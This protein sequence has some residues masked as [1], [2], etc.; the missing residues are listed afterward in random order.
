MGVRRTAGRCLADST[1]CRTG[2][3]YHRVPTAR[4]ARRRPAQGRAR[5]AAQWAACEARGISLVRGSRWARTRSVPTGGVRPGRTHLAV[6]LLVPTQASRATATVAELTLL[7]CLGPLGC[8]GSQGLMGCPAGPG[9]ARVTQDRVLQARAI[10][11]RVPSVPVTQARVLRVRVTRGRVPRVRVTRGR[12][13]LVR[14]TRGQV[15]P[16]RV[17]RVRVTRGRVLRVRVQWVRVT[18]GRVPR[19]RVSRVP[20]RAA[21]VWVVRGLLVRRPQVRGRQAR[22]ARGGKAGGVWG[23]RPRAV[24]AAFPCPGRRPEPQRR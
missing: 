23:I 3:G 17:L 19:V 6:R 12:V 4:T 14:V 7:E 10:R 24:C 13:P 20:V 2:A 18:R 1:G 22:V 15:L 11:A 5:Q 21:R 8:Q 9:R 16:V